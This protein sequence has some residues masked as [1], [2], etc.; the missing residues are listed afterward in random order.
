MSADF[1]EILASKS[2]EES[3]GPIA[4]IFLKALRFI[5][6]TMSLTVAFVIGIAASLRY[7][8]KMDMY[9]IEDFIIIFAYWL[10]FSGGAYGAYENSHITAD[11]LT[12]YMKNQKLKRGI[13]CFSSLCTVLL[14][15]LFAFW[16]WQMFQWQLK[17]GG[18]SPIWRIPLFVPQS[19]I[20]LGLTLM[21]FYFGLHFLENYRLFRL[22]LAG[23]ELR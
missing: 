12:V 16:G 17:M 10:Y 7:I 1:Q 8:F 20:T 22:A 15:G 5:M 6:I 19:A 18:A 14:S 4:K 11:I 2:L 3:F 21:T 13:I 9:G 23:K